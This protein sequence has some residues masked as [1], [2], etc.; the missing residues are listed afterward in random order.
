MRLNKIVEKCNFKVFTEDINL[1]DIEIVGGYT[2]DLLSDVMAA[3]GAG[4]IWV[5]IQRHLNIIAVAKL[6]E[7]PAILITRGLV[8]ENSTIEKA[9][10]EGVVLLGTELNSFEATGRIYCL[11]KG[12]EGV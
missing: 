5:T 8:P 2:S 3:C 12:I 11:L 9:R 10:E 4:S 1:E 6:K 7:I